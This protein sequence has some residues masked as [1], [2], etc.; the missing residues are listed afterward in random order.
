M[1]EE[2][3]LNVRGPPVRITDLSM[4]PTIGGATKRVTGALEV[5][6][7]HVLIG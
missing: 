4:R 6:M 3:K 7:G 2:L 1:Q 5:S